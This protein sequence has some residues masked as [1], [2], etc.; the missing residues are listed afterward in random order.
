M[1][2]R[3][4]PDVDAWFETY[5]NPQKD[6]VQAVRD[7]VLGADDRVTETIKW[8]APT[9][10]YAGNIASFYP[11]SKQHVSL[12]FHQGASLPD[13]EGLLEGE[14]D[15]SRVAKFADADD[16]AAKA[17][18]LQGLVRAWVAARG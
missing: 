2:D 17:D 5:E 15:T 10:V 16:L 6:L 13:P 7:V 11:R 3:H 9:F 8:Q 14:G 18:A 12:M 1:V 4:H